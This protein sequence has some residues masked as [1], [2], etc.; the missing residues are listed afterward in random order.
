M[1]QTALSLDPVRSIDRRLPLG[2]LPDDRFETVMSFWRSARGDRLMPPCKSV[3]PEMLRGALGY[4]N[5][6]DV[7]HEDSARPGFRFRLIGS[8]VAQAYGADMTGRRVDE[9]QPEYYADIIQRQFE[10]VVEERQ[11]C[12]HEVRFYMDWREHWLVRLSVPL[13]DSD[14]A[15]ERILTISAFDPEIGRFDIRDFT[16]RLTRQQELYAR[17]TAVVE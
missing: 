13:G 16:E 12:L 10:A 17:V 6:V 14:G 9:V 8:E 7:L 4:V 15:V 11:P 2:E 5:L 3:R 1:T